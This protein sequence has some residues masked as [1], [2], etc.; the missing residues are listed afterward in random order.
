M[1]QPVLNDLAAFLMIA[2]HGS[3]RRAATAL[4]LSPSALS[5]MMRT[6]E[7]RLGVRL[8]NRTTR[9]VALT[10]AGMRLAT[11]LRPALAEVDSAIAEMRDEGEQLRGRIRIT[12]MR[13]GALLLLERGLIDFH[14]RHPQVEIELTVDTALVDLVA[15]GFDA[16]VRF[17]DQVP[18]DMAVIPIAAPTSLVAAAAPGY[19]AR[20]PKPVRPA[21][22]ANHRCL[23]QKLAN[24]TIYRWEF[25]D[26]G[27]VT[28]I[29]P[30]GSL[31]TN[32]I[33]AIVAAAADGAGICY[34]PAHHVAKLIEAGALV[35]LLRTYSPS[36]EGHCLY[37][38]PTRHPTRAFAAFIKHLRHASATIDK[39]ASSGYP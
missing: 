7:D 19:L 2:Q 1:R 29:D 6:L 24:G 34:V 30:P 17:R 16:G 36:F 8:L 9:S 33:D 22:L 28:A 21:D 11:R 23:R 13:H 20:H 26:A 12:T 5:H 31:T 32:S 4:Q 15:A 25:E 18:P 35:P 14:D 3:F 10:E 38:P 39:A 27:R 37:Y